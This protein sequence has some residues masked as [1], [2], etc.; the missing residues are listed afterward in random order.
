[1]NLTSIIIPT[2]DPKAKRLKNC[3]ASIE[4]NT[5]E[6][7]EVLVI[8]DKKRTGFAVTCN[9]GLAQAKGQLV[10]L[11]NDDVTVTAGWLKNMLAVFDHFPE[12][13]LVGPVSDR[14]SG[15]Q[16]REPLKGPISMEVNRLVGFCLLIKREVIERIGGMDE[17]YPAGFEDDDYTLRALSAGFRARIALDSFVHHMGHATFTEADIDFAALQEKGWGIFSAKWQAERRNGGYVVQIP[18]WDNS[19]YVPLKKGVNLD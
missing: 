1:M 3:L 10:C 7:H 14:V 13:G 9:R 6:P 8:E 17:A 11:L 16:Q 2:I 12:V 18:E 4:A 19:Y 15:E 5:S